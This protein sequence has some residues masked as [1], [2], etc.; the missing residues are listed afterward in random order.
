MRSVLVIVADILT[1]E[2]FEAALVEHDD[3]VKQVAVAVT[4]EAF[5]NTILPW[6][7][8]AGSF[9]FDAEA[10]NHLDDFFTEIAAALEDQVA[11]CGV[12]RKGFAKLLDRYPNS[13]KRLQWPRMTLP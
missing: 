12:V 7:L 10:P 2:P 13:S 3:M 6:T 8:K 1:H 9:G 4:N 5:R 11:W